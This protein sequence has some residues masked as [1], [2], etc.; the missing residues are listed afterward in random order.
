MDNTSR[1]GKSGWADLQD[2]TVKVTD[3][4]VK[5]AVRTGKVKDSGVKVGDSP[6][7][8]ADRTAKWR[9]AR[10]SSG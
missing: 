5:V 8:V 7:K 9:I 2:R 6:V 1:E 10:T 4:G 3:S